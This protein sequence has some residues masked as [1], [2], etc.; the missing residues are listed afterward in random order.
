MSDQGTALYQFCGEYGKEVERECG[1]DL[2]GVGGAVPEKIEQV[3][4]SFEA[5]RPG[6]VAE[7]RRLAVPVALK[8]IERMNESRYLKPHLADDPATIKNISLTIGFTDEDPSK[9]RIDS[10]LILGVK[11]VVIYSIHNEA[12][13]MLI[14]LHE[15]SFDEALKIWEQDR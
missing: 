13:T 10:V 4:I 3:K 11:N 15:E 2:F 5:G 12:K 9:N 1:W 8:M 7:A 14:D 6:T